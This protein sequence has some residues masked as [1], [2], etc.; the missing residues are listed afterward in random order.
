VK[1]TAIVGGAGRL[2][3]YIVGELRHIRDLVVLDRNVSGATASA[4]IVDI[5]VLDDLRRTFNGVDEVIHVA[6]I[7]GHVQA[8]PEDFFE[9]NVMGTWNVLQAAVEHGIRKVVVTSS[10]SATGFN[11]GPPFRMPDYFPID[12][13]H[14]LLPVDAYGLS[15]QTNE[16]TAASFGRRPGMQ[17]ICIRPTYVVFPELVPHLKRDKFEGEMPDAF[18]ETPPLLRTYI[19]PRDLA[20]CYRLALDFEPEGYHLFWACAADTFEPMPTL[21]YFKRV[22]GKLPE[23]RKPEIYRTNP[24]AGVIDCSRARN[25]LNW[26]PEFSWLQIAAV[27]KP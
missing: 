19:D 8:P 14:S 27:P 9:T 20:R 16:V 24:N 13:E 17:V 3:R 4:Q 18:R 22:Y 10:S 26:T 23:I 5:T 1:K 6:G 25:M 12:E 21:D 7:D 11:V 2:G 15:K